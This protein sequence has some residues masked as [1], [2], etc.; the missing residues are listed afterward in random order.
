[1]FGK[2]LVANRGEVAVRVLRALRELEIP[3][4]AV[5]SEADRDAVHVRLADEAVAIGP[6]PAAQSYLDVD[7]VLAACRETGCDALHPGYGFLSENASFARRCADRGIVFVG[8]SPEAI[9]AMGEKTSARRLATELGVPVV[10]GSSGSVESVAAAL[11]V[12]GEVG[13]PVAVKASGGGGGI[14][15]RVAADEEELAAAL[16]A[17]RADGDRFFGNGTVYVERYFED[18]RHVEIQVLGDTHGNL[19][20]LGGRDCSVQRRHQ[21]LVE[22][23]PAPTVDVRLADRLSGYA[24]ELARAI[25][26]T[27]AGT[28]EGLLV[29]DEFYFLE[30]N[31]RLQVEH[32]VTELVTGIDLVQ[33]Q[34]RVAAGLP[35]GVRQ[36]DVVLRGVAIECRINAEAAHRQFLPSPG[37]IDRYREPT[38]PGVRVDSGVEEGTVVTPF[39]DSLLAKVVTWGPTREEATGRMIDAL[40]GFELGGV[41]SLIPFHRRLLE[42]E[43]WR[44]AETC[45][46]LLGDRA[47]LKQAAAPV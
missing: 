9:E 29:G 12:A 17:V 5:Y 36:E 31:T 43:Q 6:A 22:E 32:P 20:Q 34:I 28:I 37:T 7:A 10:P 26:Y 11:E 18:P 42:T 47:W 3:S 14:G 15:F 39:Y 2:V 23:S 35:L 30:M 41:T 27:S 21:K 8:P 4:V 1:M 46:D 44:A 19:I 16:G 24:L 40:D 33:E 38:G 25:G 13:Y 45:R